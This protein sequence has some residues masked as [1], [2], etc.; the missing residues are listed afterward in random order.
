MKIEKLKILDNDK[1]DSAIV[2]ADSII[3][4]A[5]KI[6]YKYG[7]VRARI[8]LAGDYCFVGQYNSAKENLD[9]AKKILS[10]TKDS[11]TLAKMYDHYGV[12]YSMQ[13]KFDSSHIFYNK[14]IEIARLRNDGPTPTYN[15][16]K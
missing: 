13:N 8:Y 3:D 6:N 14:S 2:F 9:I 5:K 11:E 12:M 16:S 1:L 4:E 15:A 7:E 10:Q